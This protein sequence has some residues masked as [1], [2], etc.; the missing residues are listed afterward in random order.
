M[1]LSAISV[2]VSI[3]VTFAAIMSPIIV[4]WMDHRYQLKIRKLELSQSHFENNT[5]HER[6]IWENYLKYAGHVIYKIRIESQQSYGEYYFK[7]LLYAPHDIRED[8][9][10]INSLIKSDPTNAIK[11]FEVMIPKI[12]QLIQLQL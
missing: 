8:M 5:L 7:A 6:E 2:I 11:Q 3:S 9:I 4:N 10:A 12:R 1:D